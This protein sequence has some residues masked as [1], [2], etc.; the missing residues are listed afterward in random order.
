MLY[1]HISDLSLPSEI[2]LLVIEEMEYDP[3]LLGK[4]MCISKVST[5]EAFHRATKIGGLCIHRF[6]YLAISDSATL[7]Q[8]SGFQ[9][10]RRAG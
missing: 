5:Q 2:I 7:E 10:I 3:R 8:I 1:S 4:L 6:S 9:E